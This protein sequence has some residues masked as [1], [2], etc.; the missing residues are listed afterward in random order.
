MHYSDYTTCYGWHYAM[1]LIS[2]LNRHGN[3]DGGLAMAAWVGGQSGGERAG[4][5]IGMAVG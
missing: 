5:T 1:L 4:H 3:T 2:R